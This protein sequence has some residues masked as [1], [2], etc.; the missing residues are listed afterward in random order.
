L[1]LR[2]ILAIMGYR[3]L[4]AVDWEG[5]SIEEPRALTK[6]KGCFEVAFAVIELKRTVPLCGPAAI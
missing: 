6:R 3:A 2:D 4:E 1:N 5:K